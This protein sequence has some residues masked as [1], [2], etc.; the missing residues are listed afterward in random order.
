MHRV[1]FCIFLATATVALYSLVGCKSPSGTELKP[2]KSGFLSSVAKL[3]KKHVHIQEAI[4]YSV[5]YHNAYFTNQIPLT[6]KKIEASQD[7]LDLELTQGERTY[8]FRKKLNAYPGDILREIF[9]EIYKTKIVPDQADQN[10]LQEIR[11]LLY[12]GNE[13]SIVKAI[14]KI[15]ARLRGSVAPPPAY[16][17]AVAEGYVTLALMTKRGVVSTFPLDMISRALAVRALV[18]LYEPEHRGTACADAFL[19]YSTGNRQLATDILSSLREQQ[20]PKCI[21]LRTVTFGQGTSN[22]DPADVYYW[23]LILLEDDP[24]Q[25]K[26]NSLTELYSSDPGNTVVLSALVNTEIREARLYSPL[27]I[28]ATIKQHL[29]LIKSEYPAWAERAYHRKKLFETSWV[30]RRRVDLYQCFRT[31]SDRLPLIGNFITSILSPLFPKEGEPPYSYLKMINEDIL[32]IQEPAQPGS[33][34]FS[35]KDEARLFYHDLMAALTQWHGVLTDRWGVYDYALDAAEQLNKIFG[36][37]PVIRYLYARTMGASGATQEA[38]KILWDIVQ[39]VGDQKLLLSVLEYKEFTRNN[40]SLA[41][42]VVESIYGQYPQDGPLCNYLGKIILPVD[43]TSRTKMLAEGLKNAPWDVEAVYGFAW[44]TNDFGPMA[45]L[46]AA[47]PKSA[48]V[49]YYAA[50][51]AYMRMADL[52]RAAELMRTAWNLEPAWAAAARRLGEFLEI[53]GRTDE[54]LKVYRD[55]IKIDAESLDS[56]ELEGKIG[57][58]YLKQGKS[59]D[60]VQIFSRTAGSYKAS[61]MEGAVLSYLH[62]GDAATAEEW[63]RRLADRYPGIGSATLLCKLY[64]RTG[65]MDK[66]R[67]TLQQYAAANGEYA[68]ALLRGWETRTIAPARFSKELGVIIY[69]VLANGLAQQLGLRPGDVILSYRGKEIDSGKDLEVYRFPLGDTVALTVARGNELLTF[70]IQSNLMGIY[71]E[72]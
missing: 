61:A 17:E 70:K 45:K 46:L 43:A 27:L 62:T 40:P 44:D 69:E 13:Y 26:M 28:T 12:S 39:S 67:Q 15:E 1:K 48:P 32:Q 50:E 31:F 33:E 37:D 47:R 22:Q 38:Y 64:Y 16:L 19:A 41:K 36:R 18:T 54:A 10:S 9:Q 51:L 7:A 58:I 6:T 14:K 52:S 25:L 34:F 59:R 24:T 20:E 3:K 2:I 65:Q 8:S 5:S 11:D 49:H 63:G 23:K 66:L 57:Y 60:A 30:D 4:E 68:S 42:D 56:I 71:Y 53:Q 72:N 55:Y 35:E 21:A 29:D